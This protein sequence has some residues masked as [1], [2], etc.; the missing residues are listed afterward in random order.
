MQPWSAPPFLT[1]VLYEHLYVLVVFFVCFVSCCLMIT[2]QIIFQTW[3]NNKVCYLCKRQLEHLKHLRFCVLFIQY[4]M[5]WKLTRKQYSMLQL[6]LN[7]WKIGHQLGDLAIHLSQM[8][9]TSRR[10]LQSGCMMSEHRR[11]A[12]DSISDNSDNT[13]ICHLWFITHQT[14]RTTLHGKKGELKGSMPEHALLRILIH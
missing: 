8:Y 4:N 12:G 7:I 13:Y 11:D 10:Q 3:I 6:R 2:L 14:G 9:L 5:A 1:C